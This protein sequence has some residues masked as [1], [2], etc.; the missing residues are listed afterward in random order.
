MAKKV[1]VGELAKRAQEAANSPRQHK[2]PQPAIFLLGIGV[3]LLFAALCLWQ[4]F[5]IFRASSAVANAA[6]VA[7]RLSQEL[8]QESQSARNSLVKVSQSPEVLKLVTE[9]EGF[10]ASAARAEILKLIPECRDADVIR[11][12]DVNAA[13]GGRYAEFGFAKSEIGRLNYC[14]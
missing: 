8:A 13:L 5:G 3:G 7:Q 9:I 14:R 10:D 6:D 2:E 1:T 4:A 11:G 12:S